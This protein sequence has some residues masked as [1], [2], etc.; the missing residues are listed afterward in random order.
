MTS[1]ALLARLAATANNPPIYALQKIRSNGITRYQ[2]DPGHYAFAA[3]FENVNNPA[4]LAIAITTPTTPSTAPNPVPP[5][6]ALTGQKQSILID[7][8][9]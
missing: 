1:L 8:F 3:A 4:T 2:L 9:V 7:V 5:G 6:T